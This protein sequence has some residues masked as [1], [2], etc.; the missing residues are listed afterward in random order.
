MYVAGVNVGG[1]TRSRPSRR[2]IRR[3]STYGT[4]TLSVKPPDRTLT[5]AP[6]QTKVALDTE[7][8]VEEAWKYGRS[9][10]FFPP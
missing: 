2:S 7:K 9:R 4:S 10:V 3:Y 1:M 5:F 6:E 8:A